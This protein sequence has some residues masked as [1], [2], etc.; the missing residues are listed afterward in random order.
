M[1]GDSLRDIDAALAVGGRPILVLTGNGL[2]T[3][4]VLKAR[5]AAVETYG[6]LREAAIALLK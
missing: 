2:K 5:G 4:S 1:I 6:N 3:H